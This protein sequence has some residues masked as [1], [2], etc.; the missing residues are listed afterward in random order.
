[1]ALTNTIPKSTLVKTKKACIF[2]PMNPLYLLNQA[3]TLVRNQHTEMTYAF[4]ASLVAALAKLP[5]AGS[6]PRRPISVACSWMMLPGRQAACQAPTKQA[7]TFWDVKCA[8]LR[9]LN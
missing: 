2:S 6:S 4:R 3:C 5:G 9:A 1:L 8:Q 7:L